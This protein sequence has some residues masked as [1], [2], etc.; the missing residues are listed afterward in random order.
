M[1]LY[2]MLHSLLNVLVQIATKMGLPK[3]K[4]TACPGVG[5]ITGVCHQ[6]HN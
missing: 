6:Q 2:K 1:P 4:K 3:K 5:V